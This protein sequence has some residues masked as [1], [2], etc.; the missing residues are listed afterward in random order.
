MKPYKI[1]I[2]KYAE[3][4]VTSSVAFLGDPH[5][6]PMGMD[7]FMWALS[8]GEHTVVVDMGFTEQICRERERTWVADPA[9]RLDA[10]GIDPAQVEHVIISHMHWD[11]VGN[12]ALFPKATFYIQED[13]MAFYTGRYVK[14]PSFRRSIVVEDVLSLVRFN[15][16]GRIGFCRGSEDIVPGVKV[17][18]VSGHTMG[19]Q[20]VEVAT[21]SGT[22]V[23]ASDASH[24]YRN[25][26]EYLP[27]STL[28]DI[29]GMLDG[30]ELIRRLADREELIVPGHDPEVL[31]RIPLVEEGIA[32]LE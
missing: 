2:M 18:R 19:M 31:K 13:E 5:M 1:H 24:Y 8:N 20:I 3:R 10:V 9:A 29:P 30:F 14:Y 17:H 26:Q 6:A 21:A 15:Y 7:Y 27:F 22:A 28:H 12:Y 32:L 4:D 23:L 11:H 16:A 25:Y